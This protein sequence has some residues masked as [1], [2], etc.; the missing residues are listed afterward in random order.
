MTS[1]IWRPATFYCF[2]GE[3]NQSICYTSICFVGYKFLVQFGITFI[4]LFKE[5]LTM[6]DNGNKVLVFIK[7]D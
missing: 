5:K 2:N 6:V 4:V 7:L 1:I 3:Y